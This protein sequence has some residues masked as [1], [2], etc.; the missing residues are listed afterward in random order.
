MLK[1][2]IPLDE[3]PRPPKEHARKIAYAAA[4]VKDCEWLVLSYLNKT[5]LRVCVKLSA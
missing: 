1:A 5:N 3:K 2:R 4:N